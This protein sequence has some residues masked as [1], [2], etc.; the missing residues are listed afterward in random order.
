M[1]QLHVGVGDVPGQ[2]LVAP[3]VVETDQG[4]PDEPGPTEGEDV[5]GRVVEEDGHMGRTLGIEA[6]R[7]EGGVAA[8][9]FQELPMGEDQIAEAQRRPVGDGG[10][11]PVVPQEGGGIGCRQGCLTRRRGQGH[12]LGHLRRGHD[13]RPG[14]AAFSDHGVRLVRES[15]G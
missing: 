9:L 15:P 6:G 12:P 2:V 14:G 10:V 4:G 1:T 11:G 8:G 13:V 5:L 7:E 3:G